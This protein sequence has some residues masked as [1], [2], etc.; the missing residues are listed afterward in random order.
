VSQNTQTDQGDNNLWLLIVRSGTGSEFDFYKRA[1]LTD[2][3]R[4]IPS[5]QHYSIAQLAGRAMQVGVMSGAWNGSTSTQRP[6]TFEHFMLD[7]TS[8]STLRAVPD[9]NGNI[10]ISWPNVFGTLEHTTSLNPQNWQAV[11]GTPFLGATGYSMT[12]PATP[13]ASDYFRLKQ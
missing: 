11:P 10:I 1:S 6:V 13:G 2:P 7:T 5:K 12:V 4:Q 9:G 3:W 8:G